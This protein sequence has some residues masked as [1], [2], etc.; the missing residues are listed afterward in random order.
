MKKII[1]VF[2]VLSMLVLPSPAQCDMFGGDVVVLGNILV[3]AIQQLAQLKSILNTGQDNLELLKNINRGLN[4]SL[5]MMR[6]VSPNVDPGIYANWQKGVGAIQMVQSIYGAIVPSKEARVQQDADQSVAEAVTLNNSIYTYSNQ[7]D[8][9][10]EQIKS[11][12]HSASPGGAQKLTVE[13]LGVMLH[14]L[15]QSLRAQATGLKLQAQALAIE[16]HRDKENSRQLI[17]DAA[18]LTTAMKTESM[19]FQIPRF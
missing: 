12:S 2:I 19:N 13:T 9:L 16:N 5:A 6:T 18:S 7:I 10:G 8:E 14:V 11:S 15:N 3:N 1:S 17:A 4:D